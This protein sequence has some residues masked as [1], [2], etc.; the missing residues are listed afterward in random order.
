MT[1][2]PEAYE[3]AESELD[4]LYGLNREEI[5]ECQKHLMI[6]GGTRG[7]PIL[8]HGRGVRV[9]DLDGKDYIDCTSQSAAIS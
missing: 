6:G 4:R 3:S 2:N 7:G 1:M 5:V 9:W 8:H